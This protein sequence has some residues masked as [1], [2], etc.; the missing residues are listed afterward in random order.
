M[1]HNVDEVRYELRNRLEVASRMTHNPRIDLFDAVATHTL[2]L[3]QMVASGKPI[4]H[5][6]SAS[7]AL[8][9][10]PSCGK[11]IERADGQGFLDHVAVGW[12]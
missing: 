11:L 4:E 2:L 6:V 12:G 9:L 8:V 3:V 1:P 10:S 7:Y 5:L